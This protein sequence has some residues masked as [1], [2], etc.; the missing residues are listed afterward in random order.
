M[1]AGDLYTA[2]NGLIG[3][4][5]I[6]RER[7]KLY[8]EATALLPI[9]YLRKKDLEKAGKM[10]VEAFDCINNIGTPQRRRTFKRDLYGRLQGEAI[11]CGL[12]GS[13]PQKIRPSNIRKI[14]GGMGKNQE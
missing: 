8:L 10:V 11:I 13:A 6:V 1:E 2:E 4:R 12:K 5:K 9:C 14:S 3:V 7:T